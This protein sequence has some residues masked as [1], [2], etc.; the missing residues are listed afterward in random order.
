GH[1]ADE[2]QSEFADE[3]RCHFALQQPQLGTGHA[4][5]VTRSVLDQIDPP[6]VVV[7]PGDAPLITPE[8]IERLIAAR[9]NENAA[10]SLATASLDDPT[11]YGRIIRDDKDRFARIVEE[12]D[13]DE[14]QKKIC[15]INTGY[16]C[17]QTG[18]L[19]DALDRIDDQNQ[20]GEYYL[21]DVPEILRQDGQAVAL[22]DRVDPTQMLGANTPEQLATIDELLRQRTE[23]GA[24]P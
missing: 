13:A 3:P 20:Q 4:V 21:T 11:G 14:S 19:F 22:V 18:P 2:V 7:L 1:A 17:F 15:E 8:T 16:A 24:T 10:A 23:T 9:R 6:E 5:M 12:K